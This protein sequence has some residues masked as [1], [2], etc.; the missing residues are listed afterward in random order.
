[1]HVFAYILRCMGNTKHLENKRTPVK[2][3]SQDKNKKQTNKQNQTKKLLSPLQ[4]QP[5]WLAQNG[6]ETLRV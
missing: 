3:I 4:K 6:V 1:M 2:F 5:I